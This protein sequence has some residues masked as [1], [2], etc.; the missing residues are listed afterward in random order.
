MEE[1]N[2]LERLVDGESGVFPSEEKFKVLVNSAKDLSHV[3]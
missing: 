2:D 1:C 3:L